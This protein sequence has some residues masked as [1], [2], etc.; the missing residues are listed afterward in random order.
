M[1]RKKKTIPAKKT[2]M[3]K[4]LAAAKKNGAGQKTPVR[5]KKTRVKTGPSNRTIIV[6]NRLPVQK[7]PKTGR[8]E[9][10]SGGLVSALSNIDL[11]GEKIWVGIL[12]GSKPDSEIDPGLVPIYV[13]PDLYNHYYNDLSN[14]VIWPLFHYEQEYVKFAWDNWDAYEEVNR[15][16]ADKIISIARPGDQIWVH[17][18]HLMLLP[19]FLRQRDSSLRVGF[20]LHTPFPSSEIFRMLPIREHLLEGV[21]GADLIGF[22]DY[23]YLR[24]FTSAL[25][26][27]LGVD[28][29]L[30]SAHWQDRHVEFGVFPV[31]I[32]T[33]K[34]LKKTE[35]KE[36]LKKVKEIQKGLNGRQL[37]LGVD[38][39]DYI[40][41]IDLKLRIFER[42]L[43]EFPGLRGEV[44]LL[45]IAVP[46]RTEVPEYIRSR[47][48]IERLVGHIN[49]TYGTASYVPVQ[50]M[51]SSVD[52]TELVALFRTANVLFVTSKRDGMNLVALEYI[53]S[54]PPEDPGVVVLSEFA[55]ASSNLSHTV[56]INP[57][58]TLFSAKKLFAALKM[59]RT[60]RQAM[61]KPMVEY[62]TGYNA[63]KWAGSFVSRLD[64]T[65]KMAEVRAVRIA[66]GRNGQVRLP[67]KLIRDMAGRKVTLFLDYDGTTV[68]IVDRASD[69]ILPE[70]TRRFI[71]RITKSKNLEVV[72]VS[73]RNYSFLKEQFMSLELSIASEHGARFYDHRR[74][75][76][77]S[78]VQTR[79]G[80]WFPIAKRIMQD[81][82]ARVPG[83][84]VEH[85]E[86]AVTWHYRQSPVNFGA[87]QA[88][89]LAEEL[90]VGLANFPVNIISGKKVIEARAVEANKGSFV[91]Y[92]LNTL[93]TSES[94][95]EMGRRFFLAIGDDQTDEDL[96]E[97]VARHGTAIRVGKA[98]HSKAAYYVQDQ[99]DVLPFLKALLDHC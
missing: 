33:R 28:A 75:K 62:L 40:K 13:D 42:M 21:L 18:Y 99:Q 98:A 65:N 38:R 48:E 68:P 92:Y 73:G 96:F 53:A 19:R 95:E 7:N 20:F 15:I 11:A 85:K 26:S 34:F 10:S 60:E 63:S 35:S 37:I 58:N 79:I 91:Q 70:S 52:F 56:P 64:Q 1:A 4:S 22:H 5:R 86:F 17:D 77:I 31:S 61:H 80:T 57:W 67:D 97:T 46:S 47:E 8:L 2:K 12:P 81:Y 36:V 27:I 88:R 32:N 66:R 78:L 87:Y 43:R 55:G 94:L 51:F 93:T 23:S 72:I 83:S 49:G 25:H 3:K 89:K 29:S 59:A 74:R 44:T 24:H 82:A 76:N 16:F 69:A 9:T 41:G 39:L 90:E 84:F 14:D 30:L 45:Q 50:Y 6:S 54:Q 71:R